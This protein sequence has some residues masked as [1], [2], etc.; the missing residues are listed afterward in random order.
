M[1]VL[2]HSEAKGKEAEAKGK[3]AEAK[4]KEAEAKGKEAEAKGKEAEAK[5]KAKVEEE[6]TKQLG[7]IPENRRGGFSKV[8]VRLWKGGLT[9]S[10]DASSFETLVENVRF[11]FQLGDDVFRL[12]Y[13]INGR[14]LSNGMLVVSDGCSLM[15]YL[16]F[17]NKPTLL[18]Y[19]QDHTPSDSPSPSKNSSRD[20]HSDEG[21]SAGGRNQNAQAQWA[22]AIRKRDGEKCI[23]TGQ[24]YNFGRQDVHACHLF[25]VNTTTKEERDAAGILGLYDLRNGV[26]L[27]AA[28]HNEFDKYGWCLDDNYCIQLSSRLSENENFNSYQGQKVSMPDD[29]H[30]DAFPSKTILKSRFAL[31]QS[32]IASTEESSSDDSIQE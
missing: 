3:E 17:Y 2:L 18:V 16:D 28:W 22:S 31:W 9:K 13:I 20:Y 5:G 21:K 12:Y 27:A 6:K 23:V 11:C 4:G 29:Q 30:R 14:D 24:K 26:L 7:L 1:N 10:V 8:P 15:E 25:G 19:E 32:K